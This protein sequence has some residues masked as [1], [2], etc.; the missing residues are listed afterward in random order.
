M[1]MEEKKMKKLHYLKKN[2]VIILGHYMDNDNK[3]EII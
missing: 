2:K 3:N 1:D